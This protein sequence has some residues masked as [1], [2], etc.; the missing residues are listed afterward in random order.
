MSITYPLTMPSVGGIQKITFEHEASVSSVTLPF[1]LTTKVIDRGGKRFR[2]I[3]QLAPMSVKNAKEWAGFFMSLNGPVGTFWLGPTL[4]K[5]PD[6]PAG[7]TPKV[8]GASQTGQ[9]LI[10]DGWYANNPAILEAGDWIQIENHL[11]RIMK[12]SPS[13]AGSNATFDIW[14]HLR[15]SPPDDEP[16]IRT[17]AKG[18]FRLDGPSPEMSYDQNHHIRAITFSAVEAI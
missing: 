10:T 7:G 1:S 8:N 12:D 6:V 9:T 16:I 4:D 11:Y 18:L 14:P 5:T 2:A 17:G 13:D 15:S 3:V